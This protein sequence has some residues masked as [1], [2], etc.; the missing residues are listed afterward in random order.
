MMALTK[1][2]KD[3]IGEVVKG[4]LLSRTESFPTLDASVRNAPFH[5]LFLEAFRDQLKPLNVQ[6]PYLVAIASWMHG[7]NTSLGT[8]F[9]NLAHI[10]SGGYKR[11]FA[12]AFALNVKQSQSHAIETIIRELK[13]N[14]AKP[15]VSRE[16]HLIF[17]FKQDDP[18][19]TALEFTA[20]NYQETE[21]AIAAIEIKS[22][23]PNSGEGRGEK[24][25]IL[26]GK[27]AFKQMHPTKEIKFYIAFPFD[28]TSNQATTHDKD[29]FFNYLIEFKKFFAPEEVLLGAEFWDYLSGS[30]N[31]MEEVLD[32]IKN[33][34]NQLATRPII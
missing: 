19:H 10:L 12:G 30:H 18:E 13:S 15:N 7:L 27:A 4:I 9:E 32:V 17:Q 29:R 31:T 34:I 20:D 14:V 21:K 1:D 11:S 25:K 28:P 3:R 2:Q 8:G 24:Q 6:T 33:T 26:Y 16:N 5:D 22:V 23:R